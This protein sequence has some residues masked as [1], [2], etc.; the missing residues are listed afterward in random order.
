M[1]YENIALSEKKETLYCLISTDVRMEEPATEK[2][3]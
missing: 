3:S 2:K 1:I